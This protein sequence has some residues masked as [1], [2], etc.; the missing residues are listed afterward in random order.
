VRPPYPD[1]RGDAL[2]QFQLPG[3][4]PPGADR[5][6]T[7]MPPRGEFSRSGMYTDSVPRGAGSPD[8]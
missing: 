5:M 7:R 8:L 1:R 6:V 3:E 4:L 2:Q